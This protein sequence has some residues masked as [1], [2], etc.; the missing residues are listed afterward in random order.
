MPIYE[1]TCQQ[2]KHKFEELCKTDTKQLICPKCGSSET[3]RL[4]SL[5]GVGRQAGSST[6]SSSGCAGCGGGHCSTCH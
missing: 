3:T 1:F 4:F 6:T 2:C 5:F